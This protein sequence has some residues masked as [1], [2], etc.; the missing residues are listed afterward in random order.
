[1]KDETREWLH[2][3]EENLAVAKLALEAG[4]FNP[5]IQNAQQTAEKALKAILIEGDILFPK[6]H[7]LR[8]L[9]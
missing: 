3:A 1:M 7:R 8:Q 9:K 5:A 2:Y 6:T 4:Y